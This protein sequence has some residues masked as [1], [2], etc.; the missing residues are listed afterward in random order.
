MQRTT[1]LLTGPL[2]VF[3]KPQTQ[4]WEAA[5]HKLMRKKV[6]Q[7]RKRGYI[8]PGTV[9]SGMHYFLVPKSLDDIRMVCNGTS[10]GLNEVL[11]APRFGLPMVKQTLRAL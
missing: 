10:C 4:H 6:V 8:S 3:M 5:S 2:T 7:V 11:W 1:T 9:L